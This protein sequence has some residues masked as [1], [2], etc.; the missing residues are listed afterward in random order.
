MTM[1][2]QRL[3][4]CCLVLGATAPVWAAEEPDAN[5]YAVISER[6]V[7]HLNPPPP[8]APP[9]EAPKADLPVIKITGIVKIANRIRALFVSQPKNG[10]ETPTYFNLGEG[11]R[12][13]ILQVVKIYPDDQKVDVINSGTPAT[14]TVKEDSLAKNE[15]PAPAAAPGAPGTPGGPGA[16]G[17]PR[18]PGFPNMPPLPGGVRRTPVPSFP[19]MSPPAPEA[20]AGGGTPFAFPTR[21]PRRIPLGPNGAAPQ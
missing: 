10:K 16:P 4:A 9:P 13:G 6:N 18:A 12:D 5:P 17:G 14:L 7:F 11:E 2:L 8:P 15:G 19:G 3:L 1:D 20:P 21:T